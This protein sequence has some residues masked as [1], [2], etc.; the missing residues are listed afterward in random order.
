MVGKIKV[1]ANETNRMK[2]VLLFLVTSFL[3]FACTTDEGESPRQIVDGKYS[4]K[5]NGI[6]LQ[7]PASWKF[8]TDKKY[9]ETKIDFVAIGPVLS[10]L[11]I[12]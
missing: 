12:E 7:F 8:E 10:S 6:S 9:G 4:N 2:G 1:L 5:V 3:L 11:A